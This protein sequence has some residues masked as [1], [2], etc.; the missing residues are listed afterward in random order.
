MDRSKKQDSEMV[1]GTLDM[2][3]LK[4]LVMGPAH[5]HTIARVIE[6]TSE[7]VLQ[8]EQGSLY[9][10]LHR[11]EDRGWLQA[12]WGTS[13]NNRKAKFYRLTTA[14]KKQLALETNRWREMVRA[15]G[16]VM[17]E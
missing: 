13:E 5:G 11:L 17:G 6:Q 1:Q 16:L 2:L 7:D 14:G 4:A 12:Y 3:V 10:A 8:V 15:I 9:P